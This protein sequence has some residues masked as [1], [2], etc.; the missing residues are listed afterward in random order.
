MVDETNKQTSETIKPGTLDLRT[1]D[2]EEYAIF[3]NAD[4][5]ALIVAEY[6]AIAREE[7]TRREASGWRRVKSRYGLSERR[8]VAA[9]KIIRLRWKRNG[10]E[11][12]EEKQ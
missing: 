11:T 1:L 6:L 8:S 2:D 10:V 4:P 12:E 3:L 9:A 5:Y 7:L